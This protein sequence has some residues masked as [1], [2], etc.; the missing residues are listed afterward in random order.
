MVFVPSAFVRRTLT[1]SVIV[2]ASTTM[3]AHAYIDPVTTSIVLQVLVGAVA[4]G[5]VAIRQ[6]RDRVLGL[7]RRSEKPGPDKESDLK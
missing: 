5:L 2:L 6:F 4:A 3:P 1:I 7:F